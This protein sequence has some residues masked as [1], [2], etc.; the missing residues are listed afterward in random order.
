MAGR[1]LGKSYGDSPVLI[2]VSIDLWRGEVHAILGENGA[3]KSTLIKALSGVIRPDTG[4][5]YLRGS[6]VR[7]SDP[8]DALSQGISSVQ[9]ELNCC[10]SL[11]VTENLFLGKRLPRNRFRMVDWAEAHGQARRAL[12]Q[13]GV[14]VDVRSRVGGL[15]PAA[16]K[17]VEVSRALIQQADVVI[18]DEP[19]AALD[20][21]ESARLFAVIRR[22]RGLGVAI[23]YVSH[24]LDEVMALADRISVL[25]DGVLVATRPAEGAKLAELVHLMVGRSIPLAS[26][27]GDVTSTSAVA[28]KVERLSSRGAFHDVSVEVRRGEILGIAGLD[29]S[30]RSELARGLSGVLRCDEGNIYLYGK[31]TG[32]TRT[33]RESIRAGIAYVPADRKRDG[34][35]LAMS[36]TD[37]ICLPSLA[38]LSSGPFLSRRREERL[39]SNYVDRLDIRTKGVRQACA[40]LSGGNQQKVLLAKWLAMEPKV[41]ILDD[42]TAGV[43]IGAKFEIQ[44][45]MRLLAQTGIVIVLASGELE[46]LLVMCQ[47][48]LVMRDGVLVRVLT[49]SDASA[50]ELRLAISTPSGATVA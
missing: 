3:G 50:E 47:Q 46:E 45:L 19:T 48:I 20:A 5:I 29:G 23:A 35:H 14:N 27:G 36:I 24:R 16:K 1:G 41:L 7:F 44:E 17:L 4:S 8:Q 21:D 2:D 39:A 18:L 32:P 9:Q 49:A 42:P 30:G 33:M 15:S 25:R 22:L 34:L 10:P 31:R 13:L 40:A 12:L 37:N 6:R 11:T 28:L 26:Q 43:D 38:G